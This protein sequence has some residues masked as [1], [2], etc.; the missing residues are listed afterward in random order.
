ML[1]IRPALVLTLAR[2]LI[3]LCKIAG[4]AAA[5]AEAIPASTTLKAILP[6]DFAARDYRK[7]KGQAYA[8]KTK[9]GSTLESY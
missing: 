4:L 3:L 5:G 9:E 6:T 7:N 1:T 8:G 2:F